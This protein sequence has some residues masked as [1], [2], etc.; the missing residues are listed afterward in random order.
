MAGTAWEFPRHSSGT[1]LVGQLA[2]CWCGQ[3]VP[4]PLP[5]PLPL[6]CLCLAPPSVTRPLPPGSVPSNLCV[7]SAA[8]F[9]S[10]ERQCIHAPVVIVT[11][12]PARCWPQ[13]SQL[14]LP[15]HSGCGYGWVLS[16]GSSDTIGFRAGPGF[17]FRLDYLQCL[18]NGVELQSATGC[19]KTNMNRPATDDALGLEG[20]AYPDQEPSHAE[21]RR[22]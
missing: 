2:R 10:H 4:P 15:C 18:R 12:E 19:H 20:R 6:S 22:N 21:T 7:L 9:T 14:R 13:A 1:A 8:V 5:P 16:V 17:E 11:V 3:P